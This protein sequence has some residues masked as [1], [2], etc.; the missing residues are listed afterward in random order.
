LGWGIPEATLMAFLLEEKLN[1]S[2]MMKKGFILGKG[3]ADRDGGVTVNS[4]VSSR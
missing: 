1:E 3:L 4:K 2:A